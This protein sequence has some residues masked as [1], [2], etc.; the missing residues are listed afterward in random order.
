MAAAFSA[1][2]HNHKSALPTSQPALAGD[3]EI[4]VFPPEDKCVKVG[5]IWRQNNSSTYGVHW[6]KRYMALTKQDVFFR[7]TDEEDVLDKI[8]LVEISKFG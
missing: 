3:D 4:E 6:I 2:R 7:K 5:V 1:V 8:P